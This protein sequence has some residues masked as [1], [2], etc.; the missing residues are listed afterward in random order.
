M[1]SLAAFHPAINSGIMMTIR[2]VSVMVQ[3]CV[4]SKTTPHSRRSD[5]SEDITSRLA[6]AGK[7]AGNGRIAGSGIDH[8]HSD[9]QAAAGTEAADGH[10]DPDDCFDLEGR[11]HQKPQHVS[12]CNQTDHPSLVILAAC[13][14]WGDKGSRYAQNLVDAEQIPLPPLH[15]SL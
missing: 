6:H 11:N 8:Q 5:G 14:K 9:T 7:L 12:T 13:Q 2:I 15:Q 4:M 1:R 3:F 10:S